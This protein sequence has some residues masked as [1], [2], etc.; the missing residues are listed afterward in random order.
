MTG[1][2][3]WIDRAGARAEQEARLDRMVEAL[4]GGG[5]ECE[6]VFDAGAMG[7]LLTEAAGDSIPSEIYG[8]IDGKPRWADV[9]LGEIDRA[10]GASAALCR[11]YLDDPDNFLNKILGA[12]A[13]AV[14]DA[15]TERLVLAVDRLG[16]R[17]LCYADL[18]GSSLL[19]GSTTDSIRAHGALETSVSNQSVFNYM[20]FHVVPS[21][22][23]IFSGIEKL[24]PGQ[25]IT[26]EGGRLTKETYWAPNFSSAGE[27]PGELS[28]QLFQVIRSAVQSQCDGPSTGAFLSGGLDSSTVSGFANE[29]MDEPIRAYTIGFS[30]QGYDEMEFARIA[31]KHFGLDH[32]TYYVVPEDIAESIQTIIGGFD[33]P[34]GNSSVIP[35]YFCAA[36]AKEEGIAKLLAGDGGDELFAGNERYARQKLFQ[37]Y[38]KLPEFLR[39]SML[40]PLFLKH[41]TSD[42]LPVRKVRRY[43]E[44]ARVPMPD[45]LQ[46]YNYLHLNDPRTIFTTEFLDVVDIVAPVTDMR[47][48]YDRQPDLDLLNRMLYFDWKLTLADND[49]RKV[50]RACELAGVEVSYPFLDDEVVEF[51]THIPSRRKLTTANLRRFYKEAFQHYLPPAIIKKEKHGFGL[52]FGE[53]L[54]TCEKLQDI[55]FSSVSDLRRRDIFAE[56]FIEQL[57][58]QHKHEHA[59]YYGNFVWILAVLEIWLKSR[60]F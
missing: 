12:F 26:F 5:R 2:C 55:I 16:S 17:P 43:I 7:G 3:G 9:R 23:T 45:R 20:Y 32:R 27:S 13:L 41:L 33:E 47:E 1:I 19:F 14:W 56:S 52:P 21:P 10:M 31:A 4:P 39:V 24:E 42:A 30:Q 54:L 60:E 11:A 6:S 28:A 25:R 22:R 15:R 44:Q 35:A 46:T 37:S 50:N 8:F 48:W 58:H 29:C 49:L 40:E 34:F 53:W 59:A 38:W 36:K 57:L 18:G 51:S